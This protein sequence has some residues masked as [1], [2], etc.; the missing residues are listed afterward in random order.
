LKPPKD[1]TEYKGQFTGE[2]LFVCGNAPSVAKQY[3]MLRDEYTFA[4]SHF[5]LW[6]A[7]PFVPT[8]YGIGDWESTGWHHP[9]EG[10]NWD[11]LVAPLAP[12][13]KFYLRE[14]E[15]SGAKSLGWTWVPMMQK[16]KRK[17]I[18]T[19]A[20]F[21]DEPPFGH[22]AS[23]PINLGAQLG[24][25]MGF[26]PIYLLGIEFGRHYEAVWGDSVEGHDLLATKPRSSFDPGFV[27][28]TAVAFR[29]LQKRGIAL[30][31]CTPSGKLVEQA[32]LPSQS[33]EEVLHLEVSVEA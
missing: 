13:A 18:L 16:K 21:Q 30:I 6:E 10:L 32:I 3:P 27:S 28:Q 12:C 14:Q 17:G 29:H 8:F 5:G 20:S 23:A 4:F 15:S 33:L 26:N 24:A 31:N 22:G 9:Y 19:P 7:M 25:Y 2:R 11:K 1:C